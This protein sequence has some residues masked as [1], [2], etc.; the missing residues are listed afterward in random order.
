MAAFDSEDEDAALA[1]ALAL[2]ASVDDT[3]PAAAA[4]PAAPASPDQDQFQKLFAKLVA[5]GK[6]P[7]EAAAEALVALGS[8]ARTPEPASAPT[9][10]PTVRAPTEANDDDVPDAESLAAVESC[11]AK[12]CAQKVGG[13]GGEAFKLLAAYVKNVA[14]DDRLG[15]A[16]AKYRRV[17]CANKHFKVKVAPLVGGVAL[18]RVLGFERVKGVAAAPD[19][20]GDTV[21][22][23]ELVLSAD[24]HA[25]KLPLL[26]AAHVQL[27]AA[28]VASPPR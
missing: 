9:G 20:L 6:T 27:L 22:T 3:P 17:N 18:L 14:S 1:R 13:A 5:S 4:T 23:D 16:G 2:S 10:S 15:A 28:E 8:P 11:L 12:L 19:G 26:R 7:N 24:D 21:A 25:A